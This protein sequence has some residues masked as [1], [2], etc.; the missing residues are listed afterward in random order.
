MAAGK[1]NMQKASGGVA[2]I[3][4][5][6]GVGATNIV[7]PESGTVATTSNIVGFKNYIINGGFDV[8]QRGT[9]FIAT[10]AFAYMADRFRI[11]TTSG[12]CSVNKN[13]N[14]MPT[15]YTQSLSKTNYITISSNNNGEI[16]MSQP[17]ED[18]RT[19]AG[20]NVAVSLN[21]AIYQGSAK[22]INISIL[23]F[24]G[25]GGSASVS[26]DIKTILVKANYGSTE[27]DRYNATFNLPS[28]TGKTI[29]SDSQLVLIVRIPN[30]SYSFDIG[31]VQLEEGSIATPFEQ[32][33]YGLELSLC[34]RY[35]QVYGDSTQG[36]NIIGYSIAGQTE[37][38]SFMFPIQMRDN[39]NA[40]RVGTWYVSNCSQPTIA[41]KSKNG[42]SLQT[43]VA[44]TGGFEYTCNGTGQYLIFEKE[45]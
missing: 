11:K 8:W 3:T 23:Q 31:Q 40:T 37:R 32:K 14:G 18:V 20:K 6:D 39:P 45:L 13:P 28:I 10:T 30:G 41:A 27:V 4:V 36:I 21:A 22:N 25:T 34:Q 17:I 26:T 5:A 42:F 43:I 9:S 1:W 15:E 35:Y 38:T 7:L 12:T 2:S 29:T 19:L 44:A 16:E 24:F 33:P